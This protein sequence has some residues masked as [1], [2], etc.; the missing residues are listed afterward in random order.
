MGIVN[1]YRGLDSERQVYSFTGKLKDNIDLDWEHTE[2][3]K[4]GEKLTPDYELRENEILI[5]QELPGSATAMLVAAIVIAVVSLAVGIGVGIY[6][7]EQA[8]KAQREMEEALKRLGKTNK[9]KDVSS[10]PQLGDARNEKMD[11]KNVPVILGRHLFAPYFLSEPYMRPGGEDGVDLYWYATFLV[12]QNGLC[13]ER[14]RNGTTKLL[15]LSGDTPQRGKFYFENP[16]GVDPPFYTPENF[17][18]IV[19]IGNEEE[20]NKFSDPVFEQKWSDSLESSVEIGRKKLD[21]AQTVDGIFTDDLGPDPVIRP[22]ARFPMRSEIEISFFDG[23]N[24]WDSNNGVA[25]D[26]SVSVTLEWDYNNNFA[27]P[28]TITTF[29]ITRAKAQQMRFL[30]EID[31]SPYASTIYSKEGNPVFIRA[32]RNT[33]MHTGSYRDRVYLTAIRTKQYNPNKS[34][35]TQLTP[36]KN[37]NERYADKFCRL[38]I[39]LKVNKNTQEFMDRFNV[40]VSMT[41][42]TWDGQWSEVKTKTSNSAAVLLEL[43]TGMIHDSSRHKDHELDLMA[44]GKLYEFCMNRSVTIEGQGIQRFTLECN[45]VLTSGTR[46]IDAINSILA[47]CDG[48]LYINEF[49]KLEV[50]Y[51]NTQTVPIALLNPQRIV[52]MV[53]QRSLERKTDG[54]SVEFVDQDSD[55]AQVTHRILR[56]DTEVD[57]GK[58]VYSPMKLDFTTSYN[59][60]MWHSRRL[61]A[62]EI[63]RP[64]ELKTVVGKEGRYYKPGSLIKVQDERFKIGLGSGEIVQ[65]IRSGDKITGLKLM[66]KF[67]ISNERDYWIEYFVVDG[68]KKPHVVTRQIQSV[69]EYTDRLTFTIPL[70]IDSPDVP[71]FGNILST[72]YS[73]GF[74]TGKV[75]EA[76]RYIVTDLSENEL[77]YDLTLAEYAE[78]IY[79]DSEIKAIQP[80]QSSILSAPPRVY[81]E[82]R[83]NELELLVEAQRVNGSPQAIGQIAGEAATQTVATKTPRY[84]GKTYTLDNSGTVNGNIMN[85]N[86]RVLYLGPTEGGLVQNRVYRW[87]GDSW[88]VL[89]PPTESN[90]QNAFYYLEANGDVTDGAPEAVFS[91]AQVRSL[92]ASSIFANLIGAKQIIVSENGFIQSA[93]IDPVTGKPLLLINK[94]G[95]EAING[96]FVNGFFSGHVEAVSGSFSGTLLAKSI[97]ISGNVTAGTDFI[98]RQNNTPIRLSTTNLIWGVIKEVRTAA[99]GT[100]TVRVRISGMASGNNAAIHILRNGFVAVAFTAYNNTN[101]DN[102]ITLDAEVSVIGLYI[103]TH[104]SSDD[105]IFE[106]FEIRCHEDPGLLQLLG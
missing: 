44:F 93:E 56:P 4:N 12:G 17:I 50:Y 10:I 52:S 84:R 65:L 45:G 6:A 96:R 38:G 79:G 15:D 34:S 53:D 39:K 13:F 88:E 41:G 70:D 99:K 62:K 19:Q 40:I 83:M 23:L 82:D 89:E 37:I 30:A 47:T 28:K 46:K 36:A 31:F 66:E 69:G 35:N 20:I 72:M 11:G 5:I 32:I 77:G 64:G 61:L 92:V 101:H 68:G 63:H 71:V 26:A 48:G 21:N 105:I 43:I 51:E 86:D 8:K 25:T 74:N 103:Y 22:T 90:R 76:K 42:R 106:T 16:G 75:W 91:L 55:W 29:N 94:D 33:K 102:N 14:I 81:A 49:G 80:R 97:S 9:Q 54:Y 59:Q 7:H 85:L 104:T 3:L 18:D 98:I 27:S 60:A 2:I 78:D 67:D 24:G 87:L 100:V 95:I 58:N 73:E 57:P 1:L